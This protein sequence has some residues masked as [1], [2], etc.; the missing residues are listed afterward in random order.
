[1]EAFSTVSQTI[2]GH[3]EYA[4]H[5]FSSTVNRDTIRRIIDEK[6][7]R[8]QLEESLDVWLT[9][10]TACTGTGGVAYA[11]E[12]AMPGLHRADDLAL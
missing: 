6:A 1:M 2:I 5:Y 11:F 10:T 3:L 7:L 9:G 12:A 8:Y 4:A